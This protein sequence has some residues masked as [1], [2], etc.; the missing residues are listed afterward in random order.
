MEISVRNYR[1]AERADIA[2]APIALVA[3]RNGHGKTSLL[4]A[5]QAA[6][7]ASAIVIGDV[8][9]KDAANL[10]TDGAESG[11]AKVSR[12]GAAT[13]VTWPK[14]AVDAA[15]GAPSCTAFAAGLQSL[16]DL[17]TKAR[18][19]ALS[20]Y[21]ACEP[22]AEEFAAALRDAGVSDNS[23]SAFWQNVSRG[24]GWDSEHRTITERATRYKGKWDATT[25][26]KWGAKKADAWTPKGWRPELET[27]DVEA[28]ARNIATARAALEK[29]VAQTAV[30]AAEVARLREVAAAPLAVDPST[31]SLDLMAKEDAL[32]KAHAARRA[33]PTPPASSVHVEGK[34]CPSCGTKLAIAAGG[35]L[36]LATEPVSAADV[37]A[38]RHDIAGAD[39]QITRLRGEVT[40]LQARLA[41]ASAAAKARLNAAAEI[42]KATARA[43]AAPAGTEDVDAAR[44]ALAQA[45]A[46][47]AAVTAWAAAT[48]QHRQIK[49]ALAV[50]AILAPDGLRK[51][52]LGKALGEINGELAAACATAGWETVSIGPSMEI[53]AGRFPAWALSESHRLRA[54]IALQIVMAQRDGSAA[55]LIDRADTLDQ[56][57]RNGLFRLL[58][59]TELP[60]LVCM[61][62]NKPEAVPD[63]A[64]GGIGRSYWIEDGVVQPLGADATE[65][66]A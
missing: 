61:T 21:V 1:R 65:E 64:R 17:P 7:T 19:D 26:E 42:M 50:A 49:L 55:V 41:E 9:K 37:K 23:I 29:A 36:V 54:R 31:V 28:L 60:A 10:L 30:S 52:T 33:L 16:L 15:E 5:A 57:G 53:L 34:P 20:S 46:D 13:T 6:L 22:T 32:E 24:P 45:E 47:H 2:L 43:D 56:M 14:C 44:A 27:A 51:Q 4:Q 18:A 12:G 63:L 38:M 11:Y 40:A 39:G 59:A 66:A 58:R 48:A 35:A 3:G 8:N 62:M 25:R